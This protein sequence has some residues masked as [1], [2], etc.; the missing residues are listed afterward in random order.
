MFSTKIRTRN[1]TNNS[2]KKKDTTNKLGLTK[3]ILDVV[4]KVSV[5][6]LTLPAFAIFNYLR[7][8]HRIDLFVPAVLSA[9]GLAAL[10]QASFF[11][12]A[13]FIAGFAAPSWFAALMVQTYPKG[14]KPLSASALLI[15][16]SA[17][18]ASSYFLWVSYALDKPWSTW[19]QYTLLA[20]AAL[21][22]IFTLVYLSPHR[23]R[24]L[25]QVERSDRWP[26][27][28]R[29]SATRTAVGAVV[30]L[31]TATTVQYV[32]PIAHLYGISM[33]GV[34][35][36]IIV[37]TAMLF[38]AIPGA[39]Y[40]Y[41]R[42]MGDTW[43]T[44]FYRASPLL[45]L[46]FVGTFVPW[47]S[48]EPISLLTMKSM[49]IAEASARTFELISDKERSTYEAVGFRFIGGSKFFPAV[50]RFQFGDVRLLCVQPYD[51]SILWSSGSSF[52]SRPAKPVELPDKECITS[53]KDETR[54]ITLPD[55]FKA[56]T[57]PPTE[58][59]HKSSNPVKS[60]R[61]H[62]VILRKSRCT[63]MV[64]DGTTETPIH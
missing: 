7:A 41:R 42:S 36:Y 64:S 56:P 39:I 4:L 35:G 25:T 43:K 17:A 26:R 19:W 22:G 51:P 27:R 15:L 29:A 50:L 18:A 16:I 60:R 5:V 31:F 14:S 3:D 55:G 24:V 57:T 63:V 33:D 28:L 21:V 38:S 6:L 48:L 13:A 47:F 45:L 30:G 11:V 40:V 61:R 58:I 8:I 37:G 49:G 52:L 20:I 53:S 44:S 10:L 2:S 9:T 54:V 34:Q 32:L 1:R 59:P 12:F 46:P 62:A 23:F